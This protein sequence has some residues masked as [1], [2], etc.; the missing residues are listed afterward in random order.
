V[1]V[2]FFVAIE[3]MVFRDFLDPNLSFLPTFLYTAIMM[4]LFI[5][6]FIA[7]YNIA[8]LINI[9]TLK[10]KRIKF[11]AYQPSPP[12]SAADHLEEKF[13][14]VK[15]IGIVLAGGG[16]KG[17]FQAGAMKAIHRFLEENGLLNRVEVIAGTSIG[18][19]NALF[20]LANLV[21]PNMHWEE[22]SPH[23]NW[24]NNVNLKAL[25]AP[26]WYIPFCRNAFLT[27]DP[28]KLVFKKIFDKEK[29]GKCIKESKVYFYFTRSNV[30]KGELECATNNPNPPD[31]H[32][33]KYAIIDP[34]S[35]QFLT[36]LRDSVFASMDLPPLFQYARLNGRYYEDGGVIDNLPISFAALSGC[37]TIFVLP[38]NSDFEK[39]V[40][41]TSIFAR[42][43][44]VMNVRQGVLERKELRDL[45]LYNELADLRDHALKLTNSLPNPPEIQ[46]S[47]HLAYALNRKHQ[48]ISIFGVCPRRDL[49]ASLID[50]H[51][52][53]K[54]EQAKKAFLTMYE[55]TWELLQRFQ[56]DSANEVVRVALVSAG[57]SYTWDERF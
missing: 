43:F 53:W 30:E 39:E 45:Y 55:T 42:L 13:Q 33:V 48:K 52:F 7:V 15:R 40:N 16:A 35:D 6:G 4:I 14:R 36:D 21:H 25:I 51:E 28:W 9:A 54:N 46:T 27:V 56:P 26:S 3:E 37:D 22:E 29:C 23:Q 41:K 2:I 47:S 10:I 18:S 31:V 24:W 19:W 8:A 5:I 50:T 32:G 17:A 12:I 20:W 1:W 11:K 34:K 38:L 57:G 49:V 44:R